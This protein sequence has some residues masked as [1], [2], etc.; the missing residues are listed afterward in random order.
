MENSNGS[1]QADAAEARRAELR[2]LSG[3]SFDGPRPGSITAAGWTMTAVGL[4]AAGVS[5]VILGLSIR[6]LFVQQELAGEDVFA[7][8]VGLAFALFFAR[9]WHG[10]RTL[11]DWRVA[12]D[13]PF[14]AKLFAAAGSSLS[15]SLAAFWLALLVFAVCAKTRFLELMEYLRAEEISKVHVLLVSAGAFFLFLLLWYVFES[16]MELREW[17]RPAL[18]A[19]LLAIVLLA[20]GGVAAGAGAVV[21][22]GICFGLPALAGLIL[23]CVALC[24]EEVVRH[25]RADE[26]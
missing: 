10:F 7:S 1:R 9:V 4:L 25:F 11:P 16:A 26:Q 19:I 2:I 21:V 20:C 6:G 13:V 22:L 15:A 8:A 18:G 3:P 23:E 17:A 12:L 24:G 5:L 14:R